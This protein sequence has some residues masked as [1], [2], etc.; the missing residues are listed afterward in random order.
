MLKQNNISLGLG[1]GFV[2]LAVLCLFFE[3]SPQIL[4]TISLCSLLFTV[5]QT[6][7]NF[8]SFKEKES[9]T[10]I[11][12]MSKVQK[13]DMDERWILFAQRYSHLFLSSKNE[14]YLKKIGEAL[15]IA[16]FIVLICGFVIPIKALE[17]TSLGNL[18]TLL[19]F[20]LLFFSIWMVEISRSEIQKWKEIKLFCLLLEDASTKA[21]TTITQDDLDDVT[22]MM[23]YSS[24][25]E[26]STWILQ[27]KEDT[28]FYE[29][30]PSF[31]VAQGLRYRLSPNIAKKSEMLCFVYW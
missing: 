22:K 2:I 9:E 18:C 8:L 13:C 4:A 14:H 15:E 10:K 29:K 19:S 27:T 24:S 16:S 11:D 12:V 26:K 31:Y 17:N 21:N 3:I 5:S 25:T 7:Q 6:I 30:C 28:S 1:I 23:E 20:G